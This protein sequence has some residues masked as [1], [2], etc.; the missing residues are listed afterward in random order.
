MKE[1]I[2]ELMRKHGAYAVRKACR[3]ASDEIWQE[4]K[5]KREAEYKKGRE[6]AARAKERRIAKGEE[7]KELVKV[8]MVVKMRGTRDRNGYREVLKVSDSGLELRKLSSIRVKDRNHPRWGKSVLQREMYITTQ[9][10]DKVVTIIE[11]AQEII[12]D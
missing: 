12:R 2:K 1:V 4:E 6:R 9:G 10:W 5:P 8:G 3:E 7:F 11:G